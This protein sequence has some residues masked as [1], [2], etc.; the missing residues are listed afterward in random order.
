[1]RL[2][3]QTAL[4]DKSVPKQACCYVEM[5]SRY[6]PLFICV[7]VGESALVCFTMGIEVQSGKL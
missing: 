2:R 1:M 5:V 3:H 4:V 7:F 6:L